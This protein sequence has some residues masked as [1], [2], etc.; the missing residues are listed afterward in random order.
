MSTVIDHVPAAAENGHA[1]PA[2]PG[3][4]ARPIDAARA[5]G[6]M[7]AGPV[8][9]D[10]IALLGVGSTLRS[11]AA[12]RRP[13]LLPVA[14]T[15]AVTAYA[16]LVRPWHLRW[17]AT[18]AD[19]TRPLPGDELSHGRGRSTRAITIDAP[20]DEVWPWVAQIGQDRGGFY[21]YAWLENLAG[22]RLRNADR[23]H[24]EWQ[25]RA[26]GETVRLHWSSGLEVNLFEPGRALGLEGWGTFVLEPLDDGTRTRLLVRGSRH[27]GLALLFGVAL[28]EIPHAIMERRMLLGIR[29]RVEATRRRAR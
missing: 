22:C 12:R 4:T 8:A 25:Q 1:P 10:C 18:D 28:I 23:I 5:F 20:P 19:V 24:P 6:V 27:R 11:V 17:G 13:R 9:L 29:E 7:L 14:V 16:T 26:L 3:E 2:P 21:S 15:A